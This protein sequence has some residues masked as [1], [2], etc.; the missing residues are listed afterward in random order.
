M[1]RDGRLQIS[2]RKSADPEKSGCKPGF[3]ARRIGKAAQC[4][5]VQETKVDSCS[6][7]KPSRMHVNEIKRVNLCPDS[8]V[9]HGKNISKMKV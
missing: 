2:A 6:K 9:G 5:N 1:R 3:Q 7:R 8:P 4:Q